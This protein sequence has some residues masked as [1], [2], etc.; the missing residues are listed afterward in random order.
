M[1]ASCAA[2][3]AARLASITS[4]QSVKKESGSSA[5][6]SRDNSSY[7]TTLRTLN[8]S[9]WLTRCCVDG[10]RSENSSVVRPRGANVGATR[11]ND[12]PGQANEYGQ[13]GSDH[14]SSAGT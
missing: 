1:T 4:S 2:M 13:P 3:T 6:P 7:T 12:L 11:M 10:S 8:T 14:A 9:G 5:T